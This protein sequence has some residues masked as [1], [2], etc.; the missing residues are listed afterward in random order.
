LCAEIHSVVF[1][2]DQGLKLSDS[3]PLSSIYPRRLAVYTVGL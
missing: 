2:L 1:V 3:V